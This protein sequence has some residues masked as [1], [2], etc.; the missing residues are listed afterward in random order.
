[1]YCRSSPLGVPNREVVDSLWGL[2]LY[3]AHQCPHKELFTSTLC[4]GGGS[5]TCEGYW[6]GGL[7]RTKY[8]DSAT[9]NEDLTR[10]SAFRIMQEQLF[11][12]LVKVFDPTTHDFDAPGATPSTNQCPF[13]PRTL[14]QYHRVP[15]TRKVCP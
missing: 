8:H 15:S 7:Y 12:K 10:A 3:T 6:S 13:R 2:L 1:M 11:P 5:A 14:H 4:R 9:L